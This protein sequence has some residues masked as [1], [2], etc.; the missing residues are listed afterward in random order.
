VIERAGIELGI[1]AEKGEGNLMI[2]DTKVIVKEAEEHEADLG[3]GK[4]V[5]SAEIGRHPLRRETDVEK[6]SL[7]PHVHDR[8]RTPRIG[9]LDISKRAELIMRSLIS[10]VEYALFHRPCSFIF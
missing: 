3:L 2:V 4:E 5:V 6:K 9:A 7:R 1:E 8:G 10:L